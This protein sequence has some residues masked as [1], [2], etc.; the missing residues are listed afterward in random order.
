M[1][2]GVDGQYLPFPCQLR[3]TKENS[4]MISD[5]FSQRFKYEYA[6]KVYFGGLAITRGNLV[7]AKLMMMMMM[8]GWSRLSFKACCVA[9][10]GTGH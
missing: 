5:T 2:A 10:Q 6:E 8:K 7:A 1:A 9:V 4:C 3:V